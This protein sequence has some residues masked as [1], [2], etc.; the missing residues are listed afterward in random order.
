M[1]LTYTTQSLRDLTLAVYD[2]SIYKTGR[3]VKVHRSF[4]F[5][6]KYKVI[7]YVSNDKKAPGLQVVAFVLNGDFLNSRIFIIVKGSDN[8]VP[9]EFFNDWI[10]ADFGELN[11]ITR[12]L[13]SKGLN[14]FIKKVFDKYP[15]S[16]YVLSGHSLGG[17]LIQKAYAKRPKQFEVA[18]GFSSA[19][20]YRLLTEKQKAANNRGKYKKIINYYNPNDP[21]HF[22]PFVEDFVGTQAT[23]KNLEYPDER[24]DTSKDLYENITRLHG[25][26]NFKFDLFGNLPSAVSQEK[27]ITFK[28]F[29]ERFNFFSRK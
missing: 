15:N 1:S 23:V 19:N 14:R 3:I 26:Q 11:G 17:A 29:R 28:Q 24:F 7:D 27:T 18:V 13:Q 20:G 12:P 22:M 6:Q 5:T 25:Q 10:R 8:R 4:F 2:D 9:R 21:I 16:K